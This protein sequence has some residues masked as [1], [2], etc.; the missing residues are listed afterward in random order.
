MLNPT[1]SSSTNKRIVDI[2]VAPADIAESSIAANSNFETGQEYRL[3]EVYGEEIWL[4]LMRAGITADKFNGSSILEVCAGN[5]FL[6]YHLLKKVTPLKYVIN[7]ISKIE[8]EQNKK[9]VS[10]NLSYNPE[11]ILGDIHHL[12]LESQFDII[13]GNSFLHHFYNVPRALNSIFSYLKPGGVFISL[14]EPTPLSPVVEGAKLYAL[15]FGIAFPTFL[16][17]LIRRKYSGLPSETDLW[18]FE[19]SKLKVILSKLSATKSM[20]YYWNL[21]RPIVVQKNNLHLSQK[22]QVLNDKEVR[23][24]R[25][26]IHKD[27]FLNKILPAR[28]FGSLCIVIKK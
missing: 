2:Y 23:Q 7:D 10:E 26:S 25:N 12:E 27:A 6:T 20:F 21:F 19:E 15:P 17:E 3:Q 18:Q 5:G 13:I 28:F 4:K 16:N 22:K 14:H 8:L 24:F 11:Y 9:M 1:F